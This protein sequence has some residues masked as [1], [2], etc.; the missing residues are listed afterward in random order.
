MRKEKAKSIR[1]DPEENQINAM[2]QMMELDGTRMLEIGCCDGRLF[3][4]CAGNA[5]H[6][7]Y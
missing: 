2:F 7:Q 5:G 6:S 3:M 1:T 4:R